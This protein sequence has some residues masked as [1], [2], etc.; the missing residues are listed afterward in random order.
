MN[1]KNIIIKKII[2]N[3]K[4]GYFHRIENKNKK[5]LDSIKKIFNL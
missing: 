5:R 4:Y 1:A 2:T 3:S